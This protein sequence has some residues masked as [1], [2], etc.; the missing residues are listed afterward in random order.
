M[1]KL[2][3]TLA[4]SAP[5]LLVMSPLIAAGAVATVAVAPAVTTGVVVA[6]ALQALAGVAGNIAATDVYEFLTNRVLSEDV[7]QSQDLVRATTDA[8]GLVI[9][10]TALEV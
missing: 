6:A 7:L 2:T 8:I 5:R 1:S 4:H 10:K 3:E 9:R